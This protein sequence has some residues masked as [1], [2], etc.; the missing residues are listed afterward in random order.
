MAT[1]PVPIRQTAPVPT[2]GADAW[3]S[4]RTEMDRLFDRFAFPSWRRMF[5]IAPIVD[6]TAGVSMPAMELVEKDGAYELTAELPGM[7][8]KDVD[9]SLSGD[10]LVVKGE[11]KQETEKKEANFYLAERSYGSFQRAF[12]LPD[13]VDRDKIAAAFSKG[14]LTVTL[15]MSAGAKEGQKKIEVKAA[16]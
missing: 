6:T 2:G 1:T 12:R 11:K 5:D 15:P 7:D 4:F 8:E 9:V 3:N 10:M 13:T 14:V 16:A